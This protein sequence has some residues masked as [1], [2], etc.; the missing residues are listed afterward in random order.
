MSETTTSPRTPCGLSMRPT[1]RRVTSSVEELDLDVATVAGGGGTDDGA[2]GLRH[3]TT[4][5]DDPTHVAVTDVHV[6]H[7]TATTIVEF[8]LDGVRLLDELLHDI[9][10]HGLG[11]DQVRTSSVIGDVGD[12]GHDAAP[13][14]CSHAPEIFRSLATASVG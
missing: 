14:N 13:V 10:E 9:D 11:R 6:E 8:D 7:G 2:N 3:T 12:V 4:L 1:S 5:A